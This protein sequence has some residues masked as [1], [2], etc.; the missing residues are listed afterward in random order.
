[1]TFDYPFMLTGLIILIPLVIIDIINRKKRNK[2]SAEL[3]KKLLI[4]AILFRLFL[5][6]VIIALASPRW[7]MGFAPAEYRRGLDIV[8]AL[9]ISRSMDIRDTSGESSRLEKGL[10]IAQECITSVT[11]ARFAAA[12]G[13][14]RGYLAVPLVHD[15]E[16]ILVFMESIDSSSMTGRSTNI[17]SLIETAA[18][19][20]QNTS[21][22]RRVIV[23]VSDGE[24]HSG[25]MRNA[26]NFCVRESIIVNAVAVGSDEGRLI[27]EQTDNPD[28]H[29]V[30]SRRDA[31]AMRSAAER[32]GGIYIDG[33]RDDAAS[34]LSSH[35][36]SLAQE[37]E[38]S[39]TESEDSKKEPKQRRT[40]FVILALIFFAASKFVTRF[41][42]PG[43]NAAFLSVLII[44][45]SCTEGKMLLLE[46]NYLSSRGRH[47]E[48]VAPY[49][50]ALNHA[51]AA[52]YAEYG[53]GLAFYSLD[54]LE[55]ALTRYGN[56]QILL[57][58]LAG[59]EHRELRYRNHYNS[60]IIH[61][62]EGDYHSAADAFRDALR[63]DPRRLDAK[64]NLELS[65]I[66]ITMEANAQNRTDGRQEQKEILFEFLRLEEQ[67]KW[68]SREWA[69][70]EQYLGPDY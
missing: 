37:T 3:E 18:R 43:L 35:L 44:F 28:A 58:P 60:G 42:F 41:N 16:A 4:C 55:T 13:R 12:V 10:S 26:L 62:E 38:F 23:L 57:K 1:M 66:S 20:F 25:I 34:V 6:C 17:E 59:N 31:A 70:E 7:G 36:L 15:S 52:P 65:L 14:G 48:A 5:A 54:E 30:L 33:N 69:P 22:A 53:L 24:S 64:R 67:Q 63:T 68:R 19:A 9:D 21:A 39:Q 45:S 49:L 47:D 29:M 40:L 50:K 61:F 46:A 11:G 2:L 27:P 32:T 56:S 8:F 51:D